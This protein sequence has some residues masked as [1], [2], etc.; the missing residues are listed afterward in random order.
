V[1]TGILSVVAADPG[2]TTGIC[3][4]DYRVQSGVIA[5]VPCTVTLLQADGTS[6]DAVLEAMLARW[7]SSANETIVGRYGAVEKFVAGRGAGSKGP[8]AEVTRQLVMELTE[9][10]QLHG[11]PV[12]IRSAA[13]IK[14]WA[15]DKRL[16][17][18]GIVGSSAIHGKARDA[19]DAA[20]HC[21]FAAVK[22]AKVK[23]PLA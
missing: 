6:A 22:D 16:E 17:R 8:D 13:D 1:T 2:A 19:Y 14:P 23:D 5:L 3:F 4:L 18:A 10:L 7:Y 21:L 12:K 9:R 20:R 15:T 11:Y